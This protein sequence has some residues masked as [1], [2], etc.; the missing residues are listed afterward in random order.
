MKAVVIHGAG[1]L[2]VQEREV[3]T[4]GAGQV[5]VAM[6]FGGIC[7]SDLAYYAHGTSGTAILRTPMILGHEV[8]GRIAQVGAGVSGLTEGTA[9][10]MHPARYGPGPLAPHLGERTNL[11]H[12]VRYLGSAAPTPHQDGAFAQYVLAEAG[13][14]RV[15]P[16]GVSTRHGAVAEPFGVALHAVHRAGSVQGLD[17][18]V[19]GV[20]PIGA[21]CVAAARARGAGRVT[22]ADIAPAALQIAAELGA[23]HTV[24]VAAG[25]ELPTDV[26]VV[27]EASG[28]AA[29][30]GPVL[31]AVTRGGVVVQVGNLPLTERPAVLGNLVTREVE[32]R[33][34]YRFVDEITDAVALL[35]GHVDV[36]PLLTHTFSIDEARLAFDTA[37]DPGSGA[38]KVLL[39]LR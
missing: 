23:D 19:N 32:W 26:P 36:E 20:G 12:D 2:R 27:I 13:Q 8:A 16:P 39:D 14:I 9:V 24:N 7:G 4:P 30:L 5:L 31:A 37:A 28:A 1:D 34:S 21:L 17:V 22:A 38:G 18:L 33:G 15:L 3:P 25:E 6:E 10:T 11:H 29:T 35:D